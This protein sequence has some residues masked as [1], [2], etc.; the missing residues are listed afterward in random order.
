MEEI[1]DS[2]FIHLHETESVLEGDVEKEDIVKMMI[3]QRE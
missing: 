3:K 1:R 2:S